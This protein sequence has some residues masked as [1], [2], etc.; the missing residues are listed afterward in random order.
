MNY[1]KTVILCMSAVGSGQLYYIWKKNGE[2]IMDPSCT[3]IDTAI[4]TIS[5]FTDKNQGDYTCILKN[6]ITTIESNSARVELSKQT[7]R[8]VPDA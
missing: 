8:Y 5:S 2:D 6:E 3:G 4:L 7:S 1:G